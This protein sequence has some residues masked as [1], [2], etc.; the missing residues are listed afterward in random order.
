MKNSIVD[1]W[2]LFIFIVKKIIKNLP[3]ILL[4]ISFPLLLIFLVC[5]LF[6]TEFSLVFSY[7]FSIYSIIV[8]V[9]LFDYVIISRLHEAKFYNS[10]EKVFEIRESLNFVQ[11]LM[12]S[13]KIIPVKKW[14]DNISIL[15]SYNKLLQKNDK[16]YLASKKDVFDD[17][18]RK[19]DNLDS[20]FNYSE[21]NLD[22]SILTSGNR[23]LSSECN[24]KL[25]ELIGH[26]S[27]E[28]GLDRK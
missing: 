5:F 11:E 16:L 12:L 20:N 24:D 18:M 10:E 7:I 9:V 19:L 21:S 17:L 28:E 23:Q 4:I 13:S 26:L 6:K 1:N 14:K 8:T 2:N 22:F 25:L 15:N 3:A 27:F